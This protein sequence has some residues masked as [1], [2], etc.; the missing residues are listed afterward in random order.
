MKTCRVQIKKLN[1]N[2]KIPTYGTKKAAG[3]DIY[4]CIN[5]PVTIAPGTSQ[6]IHTGFATEFDEDIVALVFPRSGTATNRNLVIANEIPVIDSDYRGEWMVPIYN[7][8]QN[9]QTIE[10]S[11]RF[12]QVLFIPKLMAE[13]LETNSLPESGRGE[14]GFGSTGTK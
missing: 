7:R 12:A 2:A 4:A 14:G 3:A 5:E 6:K 1:P 8:D 11:E 13:F 10:P 9:P